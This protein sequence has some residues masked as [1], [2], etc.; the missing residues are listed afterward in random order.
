MRP[1]KSIC[2]TSY[3]EFRKVILLVNKGKPITFS[4]RICPCLGGSQNGRGDKGL[5][6]LP[7]A[8]VAVVL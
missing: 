2:L 4:N 1:T 7:A 6:I 3:T 5:A 8:R